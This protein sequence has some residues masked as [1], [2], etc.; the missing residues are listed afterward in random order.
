[1]G[2]DRFPLG[3]CQECDRQ[4]RIM[5]PLWICIARREELLA[6][7]VTPREEDIGPSVRDLWEA[8]PPPYDSPFTGGFEGQDETLLH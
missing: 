2:T 1:M 5:P 8:G 4:A 6:S 3:I 7:M